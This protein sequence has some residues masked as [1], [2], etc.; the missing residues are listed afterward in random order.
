MAAAQVLQ[1]PELLEMILL[2]IPCRDLLLSQRVDRTWHSTIQGSVKLKRALFLAPTG[3]VVTDHGTKRLLYKTDTWQVIDATRLDEVLFR[4]AV[5]DE[6]TEAYCL[7]MN[8]LMARLFPIL[9]MEQKVGDIMPPLTERFKASLN[10]PDAS[11]RKMLVCQ[12]PV[13]FLYARDSSVAV[14]HRFTLDSVEPMGLGIDCYQPKGY[15]RT[16]RNKEGIKM[17]DIAWLYEL[18][19]CDRGVYGY[20]PSRVYLHDVFTWKRPREEHVTAE[21]IAAAAKPYLW[22]EELTKLNVL[23]VH[24]DR[25]ADYH[26]MTWQQ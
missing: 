22:K 9:G 19:H 20:V 10:H 4:Y 13:L 16:L 15:G 6:T 2:S 18:F 11:W 25:A 21:T 5:D 1:T 26:S 17:L 23:P 3:P 7:T 24:D 12:P 14:E 8:P